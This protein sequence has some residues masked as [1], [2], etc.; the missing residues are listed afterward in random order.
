M[1]SILDSDSDNLFNETNHIFDLCSGKIG[2][3][4]TD[5]FVCQSL[6]NNNELCYKTAIKDKQRFLNSLKNLLGSFQEFQDALSN[7]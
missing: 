5:L 3:V 4:I 6:F 2:S 7:N 1:F